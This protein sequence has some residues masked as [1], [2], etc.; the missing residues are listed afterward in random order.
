MD[1]T[2][3]N[4]IDLILKCPIHMT[5]LDPLNQMIRLLQI[6]CAEMACVLSVSHGWSCA[7]DSPPG[8]LQEAPTYLTEG[9]IINDV[10]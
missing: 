6:R 8:S 3:K 10:H 1:T 7:V 5:G 4:V 2:N 9:V